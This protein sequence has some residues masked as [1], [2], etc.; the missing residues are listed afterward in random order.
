MAEQLVSN[1]AAHEAVGLFRRAADAARTGEPLIV[2]CS[3]PSEVEM[4]ADGFTFY[5]C[6]RPAI[7]ALA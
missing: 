4:L 5:G 6:A 3:H 1:P 2:V 7:E